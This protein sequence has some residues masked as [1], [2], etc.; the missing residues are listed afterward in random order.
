VEEGSRKSTL[1]GVIIKIMFFVQGGKNMQFFCP[2]G[3]SRKVR[4]G[5]LKS[6]EK[7][8]EGC[9]IVNIKWSRG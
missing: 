1:S 9:K 8:S 4:R 5:V 2:E 3:G 7:M 6:F